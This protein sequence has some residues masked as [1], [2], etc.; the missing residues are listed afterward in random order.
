MQY[1]EKPKIRG[2][3]AV[4]PAAVPS[5]KDSPVKKSHENRDLRPAV[6]IKDLKKR[7]YALEEEKAQ[8]KLNVKRKKDAGKEKAQEVL[9][10]TENSNEKSMTDSES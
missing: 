6:F 7:S 1:Q 2:K 3:K 5:K 10:K 4:V 8:H 9:T